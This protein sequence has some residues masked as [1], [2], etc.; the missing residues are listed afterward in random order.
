MS[1]LWCRL[2][3]TDDLGF[4]RYGFLHRSLKEEVASSVSLIIYLPNKLL[5]RLGD[6][7]KGT[8]ALAGIGLFSFLFWK[9]LSFLVKL[10]F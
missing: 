1:A 5:G 6:F 9:L 7:A 8:I 4:G 3:Q 2:A 10:F